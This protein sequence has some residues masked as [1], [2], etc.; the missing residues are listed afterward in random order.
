VR[1]GAE[2]N[3]IGEW[4]VEA[5]FKDE[6]PSGFSHDC[7]NLTNKGGREASPESPY[8]VS[9]GYTRLVAGLRSKGTD[10]V[11]RRR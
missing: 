2:L 10:Q 5:W 3:L 8:F 9:L 4:T 1:T 6:D 7:V 11:R